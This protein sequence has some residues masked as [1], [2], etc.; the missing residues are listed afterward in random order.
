MKKTLLFIALAAGMLMASCTK[1]IVTVVRPADE[2][3][4]EQKLIIGVSSGKDALTTKAGRPLLSEAA[5]QNIDEIKLYFVNSSNIVEV[6]KT[7]GA[8]EWANATNHDDFGKQLEVTLKASNGEKLTDTSNPYTVYAVGY[9]VGTY[10]FPMLASVT[11]GS[12][13][14][15][16]ESNF[17]ASPAQDAEEIFA[18]EA[19]V[20]VEKR[21][22]AD[23]TEQSYLAKTDG[24]DVE[25]TPSIILNRQVAGVT[26]YFTNIPAKV[27][28]IVPAKLRLI[29]SNKSKQVNFV[30]LVN[31]DNSTL[32]T[33][34]VVNGS[35]S[36]AAENLPYYASDKTG[37]KVYEIDL[38]QWF[39]FGDEKTYKT[40]DAL[41]INGDGYVGYLDAI[42]HVYKKADADAEN[43]TGLTDEQKK[44]W[45]TDIKGG[46]ETQA[47]S[48]F[49][50][51]A[52][53]EA[54]PSAK[55]QLVAG[56]VFAG[57]FVIPFKSVPSTNT[58][59]LQLVDAD[60]N[61]LTNWNV[62]VPADELYVSGTNPE[63]PTGVDVTGGLADDTQSIYNIYRNHMYSL[64]SKGLINNNPDDGGTDPDPSDPD[65]DP[66]PEPDPD[67]DGS[68]D[69]DNPQDLTQNNLLIHVND[70]WEII[71]HMEID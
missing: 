55:Q 4:V 66:K 16:T 2:S 21:T 38:A 17:Y 6:V 20:Y 39:E 28:G 64:G 26:G 31:E 60:G 56:S 46:S 14:S 24:G 29:A 22:L 35:G 65:P 61:V 7:V 5:G 25:D 19:K 43:V 45:S 34:Y 41:D 9:S 71:H 57:E 44:T 59:E 49:W 52:I 12:S 37:Y 13:A 30:N 62:R 32:K 68:G 69:E 67:D 23:D 10:T 33:N 53:N 58:L 15:W 47:L 27:N 48:G 54:N 3:P 8:L 1:T 63:P 18:G 40:F 36:P 70:Q 51:N 50:K 42:C 11:T